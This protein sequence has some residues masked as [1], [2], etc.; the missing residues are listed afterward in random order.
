MFL[1]LLSII[2]CCLL[3][4]GDG[5]CSEGNELICKNGGSCRVRRGKPHCVCQNRYEGK[6]CQFSPS[7]LNPPLPNV[8]GKYK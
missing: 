8:T 4:K 5:I 2:Y 3:H 6:N 1:I 7:D